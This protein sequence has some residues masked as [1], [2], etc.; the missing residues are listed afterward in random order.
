M[1]P[2]NLRKEDPPRGG[3]VVINKRRSQVH[4]T[5]ANSILLKKFPEIEEPR[6]RRRAV[7][8]ST[9]AADGQPD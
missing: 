7:R 2:I 9:C 6:I 5:L 4:A 8:S 1:I 3:F